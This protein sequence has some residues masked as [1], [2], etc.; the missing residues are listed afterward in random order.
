M[1]SILLVACSDSNDGSVSELLGDDVRRLVLRDIGNDII[2]PALRNFSDKADALTRAVSTHAQLPD[3]AARRTNAQEAWRDAMLSWQ[4]LE[5]L[6]V[7]PAGASTGLDGTRGGADLRTGI[8]SYPLLS[9]CTIEELAR[10]DLIVN[11]GSADNT[12]GLGALEFLLYNE[13]P[14]PCELGTPATTSQRA[15]YAASAAEKILETA[16]DLQQRWEP[17]GDNFLGQWNSAG[18]GSEFYALPQNALNAL[19][20]ALFYVDKQTKD[21]KIASPTGIG[22]SGLDECE[23]ISCPERLESRLSGLSGDN[24][25]A[26]VQVF[27]DSFQGV[28][29]GHGLN[30][31]L[32]GIG[33]DD[34]AS[35]LTN[36]LLA[37]I[38][39]IDTM[40]SG[41]DESVEA[42][43]SSEACINATANPSP[44]SPSACALHGYLKIA[45]DT[46]RG[47]IVAVLS[48]TTPASTA[49]DND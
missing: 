46:F 33:R 3:D 35:E 32:S 36:E 37:V 4:Y 6:Q 49:G 1:S 7:G 8:Y 24:I 43:P 18:E 16:N 17:E 13:K 38:N 42:I 11:N 12:T 44:E 14:D 40:N 31:L 39:H 10:N 30:E 47:S 19:S 22:A 45:M 34:L 48:L 29:G 9:T 23:T 28:N 15:N 20:V 5:P 2:M 25:K 41:F 27:L 26:N 21:L